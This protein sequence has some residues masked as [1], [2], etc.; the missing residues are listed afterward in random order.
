MFIPF[1]N[2]A[3]SKLGG[4]LPETE[5]HFVEVLMGQ[6]RAPTGARVQKTCGA[7]QRAAV[8]FRVVNLFPKGHERSGQDCNQSELVT[9]APRETGFQPGLIRHEEIAHSNFHQ[10]FLESN[11]N[12]VKAKGT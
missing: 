5:Q 4:G 8:S 11:V 10:P 1:L 7:A 9:Q 12:N 2:I 6:R 3:S